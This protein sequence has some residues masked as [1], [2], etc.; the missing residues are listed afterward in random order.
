MNYPKTFADA[1]GRQWTVDITLQNDDALEAVTGVSLVNLIPSGSA[2]SKK[3]ATGGMGQLDDFLADPYKRLNSFCALVDPQ[4]KAAGLT[5]KD[6]KAG[7]DGETEEKMTNAILMAVHDFFRW[8]P[9]RQAIIRRVLNLGREIMNKASA[10]METEMAKI[11][12]DKIIEAMPQIDAAAIELDAITRLKA[13]V[14]GT[15]AISA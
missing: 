4:M 9:A 6:I 8:D 14:G 11:N 15:E 13:S 5:I 2:K 7:M 12:I 10:K 1:M 3:D